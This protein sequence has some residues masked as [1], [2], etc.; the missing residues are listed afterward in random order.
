MPTT[1]VPLQQTTVLSL[2]LLNRAV[3]C[4]PGYAVLLEVVIKPVTVL[5]AIANKLLLLSSNM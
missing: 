3:R 1:L 5:C 2:E 4:D